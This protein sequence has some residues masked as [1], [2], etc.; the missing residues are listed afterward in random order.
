[1]LW[2]ART[3][4]TISTG[5]CGTLFQNSPSCPKNI[6]A[7]SLK[8][9]E[10]VER[11][12]HCLAVMDALRQPTFAQ[13]PAEI[14]GITGKDDIARGPP[15]SQRLVSWGVTVGRQT[16]KASIAKQVVLTIH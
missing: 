1:M 11:S 15:Y 12:Q 3:G 10:L 13:S 8:P 14:A 2:A 9:G 6:R 4:Q 7:P 5:A 16:Y